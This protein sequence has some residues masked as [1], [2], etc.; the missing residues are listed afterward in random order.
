M[1]RRRFSAALQG[2]NL[3]FTGAGE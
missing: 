3:M 2:Q 1:E